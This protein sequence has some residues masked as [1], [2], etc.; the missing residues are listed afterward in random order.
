M[1]TF[2]QNI[3]L[4]RGIW[5]YFILLIFE[6]ALRKWIFP[7]LSNALLLVRDPIALWLVIVWLVRGVVPQSIYFTGMMAIG[8]LGTVTAVS[9]RDME[10]F[11]LH[12]MEHGF[13]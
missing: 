1:A 11:L 8:V 2:D 12:F 5:A 10:A 13:Y 3:Y 6:G 4:K 9:S 7:G